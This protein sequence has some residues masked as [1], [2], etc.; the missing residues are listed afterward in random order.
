MYYIMKFNTFRSNEDCGQT[1]Y[2]TN[3]KRVSKENSDH[4]LAASIKN[5]KNPSTFDRFIVKKLSLR[6][7]WD[8]L[9]I[10]A[11]SF[12]WVFMRERTD[13]S[14]PNGYKTAVGVINSIKETWLFL[15]FHLYISLSLIREREFS[16]RIDNALA[17]LINIL[18]WLVILSHRRSLSLYRSSIYFLVIKKS[19][20]AISISTFV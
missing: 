12:Q 8:T 11:F 5:F 9:Y 18:F 15:S 16:Q 14:F 1:I 7:F 17:S 3:L 2:R 20:L 4:L 6:F 10:P 19:P 13:K